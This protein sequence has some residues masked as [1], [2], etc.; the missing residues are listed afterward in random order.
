ML[1]TLQNTD[2][3]NAI[4]QLNTIKN[5]DNLYQ[6]ASFFVLFQHL[7][8]ISTTHYSNHHLSIIYKKDKKNKEDNK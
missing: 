3:Q 4:I 8:I 1:I 6:K 7:S 2:N 5:M